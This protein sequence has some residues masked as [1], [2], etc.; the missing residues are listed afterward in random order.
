MNVHD[1]QDADE[2]RENELLAALPSDDFERLLGRLERVV[3]PPFEILYDFDD[4]ITHIYFPHRNTVISTL[5]R[6]DE[7]VNVEVGLCGNEG[8]VGLSGLVR[9]GNEPV[10]KSGTG[11]GNGI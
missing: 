8:A 9:L 5:C 1:R 2:I 4:Q 10:S 6:T 7:Q 11:A 3:L